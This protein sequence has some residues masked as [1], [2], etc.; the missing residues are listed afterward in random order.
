MKTV[1]FALAGLAILASVAVAQKQ[2]PVQQVKGEKSFQIGA[3]APK[4]VTAIVYSNTLSTGYYS[5]PGPG[6]EWLDW[7][8]TRPLT[9]EHGTIIYG[10]MGY[11]TSAPLGSGPTVVW[12][13]YDG[14]T[15]GCVSLSPGGLNVSVTGLPGTIFTT[16]GTGWTVGL[17][18]QGAG[19]CFYLPAGPFGYSFTFNDSVSGPL[20]NSGDSI[21][22]SFDWIKA[23]TGSCAPGYWFGA[24]GPWAGF[25][26]EFIG[27]KTSDSAGLGN[28]P[29][30]QLSMRGNSCPGGGIYISIASSPAAAFSAVGVGAV[31]GAGIG[32]PL[33]GG[34]VWDIGLAPG[35]APVALI[36]GLF[37]GTIE[38][39][40]TTPAGAP[41]GMTYAAQWVQK[42]GPVIYTSNVALLFVP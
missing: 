10:T 36:L 30:M 26:A 12:K 33:P 16:G 3:P 15:G 34:A 5:T 24:G 25:R 13:T 7:G 18:F 20:L 19:L 41:A 22:N 29:T 32:G 23:S 38:F 35:V 11:A 37:P 14:Y 8:V 31:V 4:S 21:A 40:A 6:E 42:I 39:P 28:D 1:S 9:P 17:N 2:V 27:W